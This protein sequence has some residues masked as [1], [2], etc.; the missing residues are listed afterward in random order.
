MQRERAFTD[1]TLPHPFAAVTLCHG[2]SRY[3]WKLCVT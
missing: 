1:Y 2:L 3:L